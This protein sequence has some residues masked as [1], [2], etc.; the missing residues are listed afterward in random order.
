MREEEVLM[1]AMPGMVLGAAIALRSSGAYFAAESD[2]GQDNGETV[3]RTA[4]G[5]A[6]DRG[7]TAAKHR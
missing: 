1:V 2:F 6:D 4:E 3:C 7:K 5:V